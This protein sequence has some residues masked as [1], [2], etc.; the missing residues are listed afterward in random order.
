MSA[1]ENKIETFCGI[2]ILKLRPPK[3]AIGFAIIAIAV[4]YAWSMEAKVLHYPICGV[5]LFAA[6][7]SIS[8]CT[9]AAFR[10]YNTTLS[11]VAK[12][13]SFIETGI[14][15]FSRN[16]IYFGIVLAMF[17]IALVFGTWP[18]F[19]AMALFFLVMN[20]IFIPFEE[21]RMKSLFGEN[22]GKYY[23]RVRRW[24]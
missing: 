8:A 21:R 6:G 1:Q 7:F 18:L 5:L 10:S 13:S 12:P 2:N 16:P 11:P 17:G 9:W 22:Y 15:R 23:K 4:H 19:I 3:I 20:G 24:I 14:F